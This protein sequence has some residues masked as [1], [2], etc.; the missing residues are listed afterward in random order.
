MKPKLKV[1]GL[2]L[3]QRNSI[4]DP[5]PGSD[6]FYPPPPPPGSGWGIIFPDPGYRIPTTLINSI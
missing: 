6:D 4:A 3:S 2:A 5:D 1:K